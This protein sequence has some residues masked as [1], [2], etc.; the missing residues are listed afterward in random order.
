MWTIEEYLGAGTMVTEAGQSHLR[1][2]MGGGQRVKAFF[3]LSGGY[4]LSW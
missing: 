1:N 4:F 2:G 3:G